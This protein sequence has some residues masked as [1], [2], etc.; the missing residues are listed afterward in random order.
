MIARLS[1]I[2]VTFMGTFMVGLR[3]HL[4]P[5]SLCESERDLKE[6]AATTDEH[7][8]VSTN[9]F[10]SFASIGT[11][12]AIGE[13]VPPDVTRTGQAIHDKWAQSARPNICCT[14]GRT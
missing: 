11:V 2:G 1:Q 6:A 8:A 7:R 9:T 13:V 10:K 14:R 4:Q 5:R 3:E 12:N